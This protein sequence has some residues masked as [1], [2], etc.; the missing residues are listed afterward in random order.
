MGIRIVRNDGVYGTVIR[1]SVSF[2]KNRQFKARKAARNY[3]DVL[4]TRIMIPLRALLTSFCETK[5]LY[6][7]NIV[8]S[9]YEV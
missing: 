2:P 4:W 3:A 5:L 8:R 1:S 9:K 7:Q 6:T